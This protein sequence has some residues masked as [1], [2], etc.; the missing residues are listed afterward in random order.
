MIWKY[1]KKCFQD[2][3][4][5]R[6]VFHCI[7]TIINVETLS[8]QCW[9]SH[10]LQVFSTCLFSSI[11]LPKGLPVSF[12][13]F[14]I[15]TQLPFPLG[16]SFGTLKASVPEVFPHLNISSCCLFSP[17]SKLHL[18]ASIL[19]TIQKALLH[20]PLFYISD[21]PNFPGSKEKRVINRVKGYR[22]VKDED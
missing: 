19:A 7:C 3:L 5:L 20:S 13:Y 15:L 12:P 16:T 17:Y 1:K 2:P 18:R 10:P 21:S 11:H 4:R 8:L 14:I 6:W 9:R 22:E